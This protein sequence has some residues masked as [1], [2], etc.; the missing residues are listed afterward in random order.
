MINDQLQRQNSGDGSVQYQANNDI[1]IQ[2]G[3]TYREIKEI[4]M[5]VF[6]ANFFELSGMAKQLANERASQITD[7]LLHK[8]L[9][10]SDGY[11][12]S[13]DP[14]FQYSVYLVQREYARTG[15]ENLGDLLT[16][17][18]VDRSKYDNR[19]ILQ[20]VL[21]E[22]LLVA[23]KLTSMQINALSLI[24]LLSNMRFGGLTDFGELE[25]VFAKAQSLVGDVSDL[26]ES[27]LLHL[28]YS[29]A[30]SINHIIKKDI[31]RKVHETYKYLS[32]DASYE[33]FTNA[34]KEGA[35]SLLKCVDMFNNHRMY[36]AEL[37]SVG[38]LIGLANLKK[39]FSNID[40]GIWIN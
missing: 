26:S 1:I 34:I 10:V 18:L 8:L 3:P 35:P 17:I 30:M 16:D 12:F 4:A 36:R 31:S 25:S 32:D 38:T 11:R 22:S 40:Y 5:D 33:D 15:D 2:Q 20:I 28:Q 39:I 27:G 21:N 37:T 19:S 13:G 24:Q 29:G 14:D 9:Q 23:P 6:R 7:T